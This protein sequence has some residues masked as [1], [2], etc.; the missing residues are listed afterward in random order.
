MDRVGAARDVGPSKGR[1][2]P[3]MLDENSGQQ[4]PPRSRQTPRQV[5]LDLSHMGLRHLKVTSHV[6]PNWSY[7]RSM[8]TSEI[9]A[10]GNWWLPGKEDKAVPGTLRIGVAG[11]DLELDGALDPIEPTNTSQSYSPTWV[12]HETVFGD[13]DA[14][15]FTLLKIQGM[16]FG[17][18]PGSG[19]AEYYTVRAAIEAATLESPP[20]YAHLIFSTD[21]LAHWIRPDGPRAAMPEVDGPY[22]VTARRRQEF[23]SVELPEGKVELY[24]FTSGKL[25]EYSAAI[26]TR[27]AWGV[28]PNKPVSLNALLQEWVG[29][30]QNLVSFAT[31]SPNRV[32]DIRVRAGPDTPLARVYLELRG[33]RLPATTPDR[34]WDHQLV[35]TPAVMC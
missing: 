17:L 32:V 3:V 28:T 33:D 21:Y 6:V 25:S 7:H 20:T 14:G 2:R 27:M 31:L 8:P 11:L 12:E 30:L 1:D 35:L 22:G 15:P 16:P 19:R 10:T 34:L 18:P 5:V 29:P 26:D 9:I 4:P 23:C 13:T 24:A